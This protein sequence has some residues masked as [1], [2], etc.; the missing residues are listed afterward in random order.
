M[1]RSAALALGLS[2]M[3]GACGSEP[4]L[5]QQIIAVIIEME[6]NAETAERR[7]FMA[8]ISDGFSGQG[9]TLDRDSFQ[10]FMFYQWSQNQRLSA[11]LF[12][13][14][15]S[16]TGVNSAAASFK[17]LVTGGNGLLPERG[18]LF[19]VT[20]SWVRVDG[21]WLLQQA[22]WTPSIGASS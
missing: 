13:I 20:T 21:D 6:Q 16:R 22:D 19:D 17:V 12:P 9:G 11:Q 14:T 4:T 5:E 1:V 3:L 10:R 18:E 2:L 7:D 8:R 15:V